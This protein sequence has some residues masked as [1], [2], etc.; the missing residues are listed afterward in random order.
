MSKNEYAKKLYVKF[1][2]EKNT[3]EIINDLNHAKI[4]DRILS[5]EQK[6]EIVDLI[7]QI[8]IEESIKLY[9]SVDAFLD[10]VNL[11]EKEIKNTEKK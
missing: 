11:V 9:E 3:Q 7:R 2:N 6:L 4:G 8:H 1:I 5:I 10:L